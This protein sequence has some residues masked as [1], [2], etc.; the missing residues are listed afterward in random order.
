MQ[1]TSPGRKREE[2]S[3]TMNY[4][5]WGQEYLQEAD[6]IKT[7]IGSLREQLND[8]GHNRHLNQ[9]EKIVLNRRIYM[10]YSMYL[11]CKSTGMLLQDYENSD[12]RTKRA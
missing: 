8:A 5:K 4:V 1:Q 6:Q 3:Y 12:F 2:W 11:D 7:R 9:Q 10:L